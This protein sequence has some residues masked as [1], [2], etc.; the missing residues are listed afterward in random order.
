M[1]RICP[2]CKKNRG[3][4]YHHERYDGK[5]YP[6]DPRIADIMLDLIRSGRIPTEE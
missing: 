6:V 4:H 3:A 1:R 2:F 5:G